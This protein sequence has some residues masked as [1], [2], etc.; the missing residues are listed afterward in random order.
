MS[1]AVS[2]ITRNSIEKSIF[3]IIDNN[4]SHDTEMEVRLFYYKKFIFLIRLTISNSITLMICNLLINNFIL[5][6][7]MNTWINIFK[8]NPSKATIKLL[9]LVLN[10]F[11]IDVYDSTFINLNA[12][13]MSKN[14]VKCFKTMVFY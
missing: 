1:F 12:V 2:S 8:D 4:I 14:I 13:L 6:A 9:T 10:C 11:N 7:I 5:K 3:T